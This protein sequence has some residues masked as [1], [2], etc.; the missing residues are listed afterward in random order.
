[1]SSITWGLPSR[2]QQMSQS[3]DTIGWRRFMEGMIPKEIRNIQEMYMSVE[4]ET[5]S[6]TNWSTGLIVK[7]LEV[8]HGQWLYRCVQIHDKTRGTLATTEKEE[9]Q[10]EI[11]EQM[12]QG[13][14]DLLEE[15]Q[16][17][18][19]VNLEDLEH[20]S[21]EKQQYWLLAIR[22]AREASRLRGGTSD[23]RGRNR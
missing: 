7:L 1:M 13:W 20:S 23:R 3:V 17:L 10:C 14:S 21:G 8:A 18:A 2:Y 12:E 9:L 22:A 11:E 15:D 6:L 5:A 16:Y 4:G 19:E